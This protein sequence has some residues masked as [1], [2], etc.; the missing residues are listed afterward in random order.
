MKIKSEYET[1]KDLTKLFTDTGTDFILTG[2]FLLTFYQIP[3]AT[4]DIDILIPSDIKNTEKFIKGIS[5]KFIIPQ[6]IKKALKAETHFNIIDP[7]NF[8]KI[9]F[10]IV[11][12]EKFDELKKRAKR[13]SLKEFQLLILS[14]TDFIISKVE[15]IKKG[16]GE[17]H[18]ADIIK[19]IETLNKREKSKLFKKLKEMGYYEEIKKI[20]G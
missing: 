10:F 14:L 9:D 16:G 4:R 5:K 17:I 8:L 15:W 13:V 6:D 2:S 20:L 3:R 7:R 19:L 1:L 18:R 12:K 11:K